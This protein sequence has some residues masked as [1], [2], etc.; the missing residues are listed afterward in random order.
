MS[1]DFLDQYGLDPNHPMG[2]QAVDWDADLVPGTV[3]P[4]SIR[5]WQASR[6]RL[7][8]GFVGITYLRSNT[9]FLFPSFNYDAT[10]KLFKNG[11][12]SENLTRLQLGN[13]YGTHY[14]S[15]DVN[16]RVMAGAGTTTNALGARSG[17][18]H[19]TAARRAG[20]GNEPA[21]WIGWSIV[22]TANPMS[23][24]EFRFVSGRNEPK[25]AGRRSSFNGGELDKRDL[26]TA[27]REWIMT[28]LAGTLH[29]NRRRWSIG[30]G[31]SNEQRRVE[32][33]GDVQVAW[34]TNSTIL[35][36]RN[37]KKIRD[38]PKGEQ[39]LVHD[40]PS[41]KG[42]LFNLREYLKVTC[43]GQDGYIRKAS[44]KISSQRPT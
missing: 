44:L 9:H 3:D 7:A 33:A 25:F 12:D 18:Q 17:I 42:G 24:Q 4:A 30:I 26:P 40:D 41:K 19:M 31:H 1:G 32:V 35:R 2:E 6:T 39:V 38:I 29:L 10:D 16:V 13:L 5:A 34:T 14:I 11:L 37:L 22:G 36:D 21:F 15:V 23:P 8:D 43:R 27:W 20:V 28:D